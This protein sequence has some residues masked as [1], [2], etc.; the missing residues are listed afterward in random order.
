MALGK[1]TMI[2][3]DRRTLEAKHWSK[4]FGK[5]SIIRQR[6]CDWSDDFDPFHF[7][8]TSSVAALANA[9]TLAGFVSQ[10]EYILDKRHSTRGRP[11]RRGRGD[12]WIADNESE[13][14]W[15]FEA[16]QHF[17]ATGIRE[18]TFDKHLRLAMTDAEAI[19]REE[20]DRRFGCLIVVPSAKANHEILSERMDHLAK[21]ADFAFRLDGNSG[22]IWL[23]FSL[24]K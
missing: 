2:V 5:I 18:D 17:A 21:S 10:T 12:L 16:K 6:F 3:G 7:N 8:E 13:F 9:A 24:V 19:D 4:W 14:C 23:A 1:V 20:A 22:P 15:V 11:W